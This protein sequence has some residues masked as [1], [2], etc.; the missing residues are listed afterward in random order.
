MELDDLYVVGIGASAGGF[1]SLQ[2]FF[3]NLTPT[4]NIAY[5]I[6]QHLDPNQPTLLGTLLE[7][8]TTLK[9]IQITNEMP[10]E[11]NNIYFCPPNYDLYIENNTFKIQKIDTKRI[12][13]KPSIDKFFSSL[14][15]EKK[16]KAVAIVLSGSGSD[17]AQG[18][19]EIKKYN[20][21]TIC[22]DEGA[23]YFSMPKAA[24][25]SGAVDV[26]LPPE[27][28]ADGIP[29][30]I[31]DR[32]YYEKNFR[33]Q[34]SIDIIYSLLNK[35]TNIDFSS[36]KDNT[37]F[38]RITKRMNDLRL[39][40]VDDYI[41]VLKNDK[42]ESQ[43]LKEELLILVTSFFRD[44]DS[45]L[46]LK[47][48]IKTLMHN[49]LD[50]IFRVWIPASATGEE[51]ISIA[52]IISEIMQ[53]LNR[54]FKVNIFATDINEKA[55][56]TARNKK[57]SK[58]DLA[59][60]S[61]E[62]QNKYF[63]NKNGSYS[64]IKKIRDMIM[65]SK[66]DIIKDPPFSNLDMISCRNLLIY[67]DGDLQRRILNLFYYSLK[68]NSLLFLGQSETVGNSS[69]FSII[70][71]KHKIYK[72]SNDL[73]NVNFDS[74]AYKNNT[75]FIRTSKKQEKDN[76]NIYDIEYTINKAITKKF[77]DSG[78]VI[79]GDSNNVLFYKG[80]VSEFLS[81]PT[82]LATSDIFKLV[83]DFL[84]LDLR[85]TL[86]QAQKEKSFLK[87][88]KIRTN[89]K[90]DESYYIVI[91][92]YPL[93]NNRLGDNTY[94]ITFLKEKTND[95]F[96]KYD[97][98]NIDEVNVLEDELLSLKERLQIT[99]EEL[100]TSNEEL[101]STNEELQSTNEELQ[102]TNEELETSNEELH[103]TNEELQTVNDELSYKNLE[104][105]FANSAF[106]LVLDSIDTHVIIID[107]KL[108]IIRFSEGMTKFFDIDK[109]TTN[110]S[111]MLLN[112]KIKLPNIL[113]DL[114]T[115]LNMDK[116]IN[117]EIEFDDRIYWVNI[118]KI[119]V[120][121]TI[122]N[123]DEGIV[124]SFIDKTDMIR[125][126]KILYQQ[127]KMASMGEMI[128]NI[129]HQ[130]RQPLNA[131]SLLNISLSLNSEKGQLDST[132]I[133]E[134]YEKTNQII[135]KMSNTINDFRNFFLPNKQKEAFS[136]NEIINNSLEFLNDT[137]NAKNIVV[138]FNVLKDFKVEGFKNEFQQVIINILNN[139]IDAIVLRKIENGE[140]QI[141]IYEN[142]KNII[143]EIKDNG[144]GLDKK[145]EN[146]I[147]EPYFTTKFKNN[148]TGLGL[149]MSKMII[150]ESLN[151]QISI[152]NNKNSSGVLCSIHLNK[153]E[154]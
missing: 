23:K 14:A 138:N 122:Y 101:Q 71:N 142:N 62:Y 26:V 108:N 67:F 150:E 19:K 84:R 127:A 106:N 110:F 55:I 147:Y 87:S 42:E 18:I 92:V 99:I 118:K 41:K 37:I 100:E 145:I 25:D 140:I 52:I 69:N 148:G 21:I 121:S 40:N 65:F 38:R 7:K 78:I 73:S 143:L 34:D 66:H 136:I 86:N 22:E 114:K 109:N 8:Y 63:E 30:V 128:A 61:K 49:K 43:K 116:S 135:Q 130:W 44:K 79:D 72:K 125:K 12:T 46:E 94:Y 126:D 1:E 3:R 137:F 102:S 50:K 13:P 59:H 133:D 111:S 16:Q 32:N 80:D 98:I 33:I 88:K 139:S 45:F 113:E 152:T 75:N 77:G 149:Y 105:E 154:K 5:V 81:Y 51:A 27:L 97:P 31:K 124:I 10:I 123:E 56:L 91:S 64:P 115:S 141:G 96:M 60:M 144:V 9:V 146:K 20:G 103:S 90:D 120:T 54:D 57:F 89:L 107:K 48:E 15:I 24:I 47:K 104:L 134:Y 151:G 29:N 53:E 11:S 70:N 83:K 39:E 74:L 2:K 58:E 131:L 6:T 117:Y 95:N 153:G 119:K 129:A 36:Y 35:D 17:G 93:E 4:E 68:H 76:K 112:S 28:I 85:A 132:N 82:G